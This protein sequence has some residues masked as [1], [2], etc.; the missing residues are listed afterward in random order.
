MPASAGRPDVVLAQK[1]LDRLDLS[2]SLRSHFD[3]HGHSARQTRRCRLLSVGQ[4]PAT[5]EGAHVFLVEAGVDERRDDAAL[6]RCLQTRTMLTEIINLRPNE[7]DF[8]G[9]SSGSE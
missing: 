6:H 1:F 2:E 9:I 8:L 7:D 3:S 5:C 4:V